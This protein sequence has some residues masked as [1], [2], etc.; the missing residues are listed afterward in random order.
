MQFDLRLCAKHNMSAAIGVRDAQ[1]VP[2]PEHIVALTC[3]RL[4]G[5]LAR[6]TLKL[7]PLTTNPCKL[8]DYCKPDSLVRYCKWR[9][10]SHSSVRWV[11]AKMQVFDVLTNNLDP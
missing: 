4:A 11:D 6:L 5:G 2:P 7:L 8:S 1:S 10:N 9:G 3:D